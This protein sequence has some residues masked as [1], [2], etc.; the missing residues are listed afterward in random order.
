MNPHHEKILRMKEQLIAR[1]KKQPESFRF[2]PDLAQLPIAADLWT[3]LPVDV[4]TKLPRWQNSIGMYVKVLP[5]FSIGVHEITQ[6]QYE[7]VMGSNPSRFVGANHPVEQV[8]WNH[9]IEFCERLSRL[10]E[11]QA[12]GRVYRLP[13]EE[14]WEFACRAG[15]TAIYS[16]GDSAK[17]IGEHAWFK[18]NSGGTTHQVGCKLPNAWGLYDMHG[19][20]WEWCSALTQTRLRTLRGGSWY[21]TAKD[22]RIDSHR[23]VEQWSILDSYGFRVALSFPFQESRQA[24]N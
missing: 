1:I 8:S 2:I 3:V 22:C 4:L 19:N 11:E 5:T 16:F 18:E 9:A 21:N 7:S 23:K 17:E 12:A 10:P 20:V 6:S 24:A 13:T 15:T 14:E